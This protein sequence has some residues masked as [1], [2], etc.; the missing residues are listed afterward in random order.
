MYKILLIGRGRPSLGSTAPCIA[1]ADIIYRKNHDVKPFLV[2]Y[3]PGFKMLSHY[4]FPKIDLGHFL[5]ESVYPGLKMHNGI[6]PLFHSVVKKIKPDLIINSG[7]MSIPKYCKEQKI[8]C[9]SIVNL[10]YFDIQ[11]GWIGSMRNRLIERASESKFIFDHRFFKEAP[12]QDF[13]EKVIYIGPLIR[14]WLSINREL[15]R[16]RMGIKDNE[17]LILVMRGAA[18]DFDKPM[19]GKGS[20]EIFEK[21]SNKIV[22][23]A[24]ETFKQLIE[25]E[26]IKMIIN[27]GFSGDGVRSSYDGKLIEMGFTDEVFPHMMA[28]DVIL[29]RAGLNTLNECIYFNKPTIAVPIYSDFEQN[30]NSSKFANGRDR[31][32]IRSDELSKD[33]LLENILR[34]FK[35]KKN[36][37]AIDRIIEKNDDKILKTLEKTQNEFV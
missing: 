22:D 25:H 36:P 15:I 35:F 14:R 33:T 29:T 17:K 3:G 2:S 27:K 34:L 26:N 16:K 18:E 9:I 31:V 19:T 5:N 1:L 4:K 21:Q 8:P 7:E 13:A 37:K 11:K 23:I 10:S 6:Y 20:R 12:P 28:A 30:K 24:K 32:V